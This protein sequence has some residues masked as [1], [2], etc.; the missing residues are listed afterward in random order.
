MRVLMFRH[1]ER[2]NTGSPNPPL[3]MRGLK[4]AVKLAKDIQ[5]GNLPQPSRLYSSP[6]LRAHQTFYQVHLALNLEL[7]THSELDE[8]HGPESTSQ[9]EMRVQKFLHFVESQSGIIYFVTHLDWI[10]E[11]LLQ[12]QSDTDLSKDHFQYWQPGQIAEFEV[13]DGL[14][15]FQKMSVLEG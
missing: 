12:I 13:H 11:A 5:A 2:Q 8:K 7:A 3:S 4:Q 14:W 9:F 15:M 1:A 6:K 10:E